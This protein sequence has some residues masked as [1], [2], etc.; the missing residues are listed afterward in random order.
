MSTPEIQMMT[1]TMTWSQDC[2]VLQ[3]FLVITSPRCGWIPT[4][5][6]SEPILLIK[7]MMRPWNK[8][9]KFYK[10]EYT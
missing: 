10:Y 6:P 8:I 7:K 1:F 3:W 9:Y 5:R 4:L 2:W